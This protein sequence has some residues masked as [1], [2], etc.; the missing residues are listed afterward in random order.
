MRHGFK[1]VN[2]TWAPEADRKLFEAVQV[3]GTENWA[4]GQY[5]IFLLEV[6]IS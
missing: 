3:Y 1:R 5:I 6:G 2:H 4:L